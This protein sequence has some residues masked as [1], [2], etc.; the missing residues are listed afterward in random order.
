MSTFF[1][2]NK[3]CDEVMKSLKG[4]KRRGSEESVWERDQVK[5]KRKLVSVR[6]AVLSGVL[7]ERF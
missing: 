3:L 6:C 5:Q 1:L 4:F 2:S 7:F